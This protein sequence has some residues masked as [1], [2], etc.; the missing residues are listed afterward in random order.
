MFEYTKVDGIMCG[1]A[2][3]G[4][5]WVTQE[6][7]DYLMNV[8]SFDHAKQ[9]YLPDMH[10]SQEYRLNVMKEHL[11]MSVKEKGEYIAVREMR[12]HICWYIKS[13]KDSTKIRETVNRLETKEEV[14]KC[15]E[16]YFKTL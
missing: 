8:A 5:P 14:I 2:I 10:S 11:E 7:A 1:R 6:I 4:N 9:E 13:L 3:F 16:Q 12:K 15:L